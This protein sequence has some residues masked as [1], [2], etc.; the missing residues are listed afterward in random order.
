MSVMASSVLS[1]APS[2]RLIFRAQALAKALFLLATIPSVRSPETILTRAMWLTV[3]CGTRKPLTR[4]NNM[5][6]QRSD[7]SDLDHTITRRKFIGTTAAT[8][9]ALL[10]GGL[11]SLVSRSASAAHDFDFV[12][13]SIPELQAAMA[14]GQ[15]S[16]KDLVKG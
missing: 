10:G 14:S 6:K 9:A 3:S 8:S 12:E 1:T 11:T 5:N 2:P 7:H 4:R 16:S 13:K 15:V